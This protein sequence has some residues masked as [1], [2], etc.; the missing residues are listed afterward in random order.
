[1]IEEEDTLIP[2]LQV[3]NNFQAIHH[4]VNRR[5]KEL[6]DAVQVSPGNLDILVETIQKKVHKDVKQ[7]PKW[8]QDLAFVGS[9][10]RPSYDLNGHKI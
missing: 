5:Y 2:S 8:P 6:E 10:Q 3:L 9:L 7:K 1:M 4:N